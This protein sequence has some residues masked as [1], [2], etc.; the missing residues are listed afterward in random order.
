MVRILVAVTN[1]NHIPEPAEIV[2]GEGLYEIFFSKWIR[3]SDM[4]G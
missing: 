2:V 3:Y 1:V 4:G